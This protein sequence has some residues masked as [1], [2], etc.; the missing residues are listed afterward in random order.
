MLRIFKDN[1]TGNYHVDL[2]PH[3]GGRPSLNV[4]KKRVAQ[5]IAAQMYNQIL[6]GTLNVKLVGK[7]QRRKKASITLDEALEQFM[8]RCRDLREWT[9][10]SY[11]NY[12]KQILKYFRPDIPVTQ[13]TLD[14][15]EKYEVFRK[16]QGVAPK[17]VR[18]DLAY[19]STF[20]KFCLKK[21]YIS[22]SP[23][24]GFVFK[25]VHNRRERIL[26]HQEIQTLLEKCTD[27]EIRVA[28]KLALFMGMRNSEVI[29][30]QLPQG[31]IF[32]WIKKAKKE[33]LNWIHIRKKLVV[34]NEVKNKVPREVPIP[35]IVM[36]DLEPF[37][38]DKTDFI[39]ERK[40][41]IRRSWE[42][43]RIEAGIEDV[44]F[45]DLRRTLISNMASE[46]YSRELVQNVVGQ[47]SPKV[48]DNYAMIYMESKRKSLNEI[49]GKMNK[50]NVIQI[51]TERTVNEE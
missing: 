11:R 29:H 37:I 24:E 40:S 30:L 34:L 21:K 27:I 12:R 7:R 49:S 2:R 51:P 10:K 17:T 39:F 47:L 48:Y 26:S 3:G 43:V 19:L 6:E 18:H 4:N 41:R 46:N 20:F 8:E 33:K 36:E 16:S 5:Q 25:K 42:K 44:W 50:T 14:D 1:K 38:Q 32:Q 45:H 31:D 22:T 35:D 28:V 13:I 9:Q 23:M 15:V